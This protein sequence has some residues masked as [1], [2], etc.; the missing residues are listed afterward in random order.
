MPK[1]YWSDT[2]R[3]T[4]ESLPERVRAEIA[5]REDLLRQF[6]EMYAL[7]D[8]GSHRGT[9]RFTIAGQFAVYYRV[10]GPRKDC[11]ITDVRHARAR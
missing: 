5:R 10:H 6:P 3:T 2:A 1:V 4:L 8:A 11:F 7:V 9:R